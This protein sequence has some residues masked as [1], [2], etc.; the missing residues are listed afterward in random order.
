MGVNV[1]SICHLAWAKVLSRLTGR[2][3]VVFGTVLFGRMQ[4]GQGAERAMG[5]FIN[6]LPVRIVA[7]DEPVGQAV[8]TTHTLLSQLLHHEHAPLS[9]A[10]R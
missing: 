9:L 2:E 4:G 8:H 10:Q 7:G 5:M 1:A 3:E 6:T